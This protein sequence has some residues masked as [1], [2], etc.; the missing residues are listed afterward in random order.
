MY[1]LRPPDVFVHE[2][3]MGDP[4]SRARLDAVLA[5]LAE[6]VEPTVYGD[7]DLPGLVNERRLLAKRVP[8]GRMGT[9]EEV[10]EVV[11][12]LAT[13]GASYI[14]GCT[15]SVSGGGLLY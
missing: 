4:H 11:L 6:P 9:A 3:V 8:M 10:A 2:S 13:D 14:T 15:L 5:A 12:F 7:E 1:E